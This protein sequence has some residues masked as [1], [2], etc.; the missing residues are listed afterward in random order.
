M[1]VHMRLHT[2]SKP[3]KCPHCDQW[4]R[5]SG[6]RK[7]H[8]A[9]HFKP[10]NPK[11]RR[12]GRAGVGGATEEP[13]QQ[14]VL[15]SNSGDLQITNLSALTPEQIAALTGA[16]GA[17]Q[18]VN[19]DQNQ[20]QQL[21]QPQ[22]QPLSLSITTDSFGNITD[23]ALATQLLQNIEGLQL[24]IPQQQQQQVQIGGLDNLAQ[25]TIQID[26]ALLQQLQQ[27]NIN[28]TIDPGSFQQLQTA[29]PNLI[30]PSAAPLNPNV[31]ISGTED[32]N[33]PTEDEN[34]ELQQQTEQNAEETDEEDEEDED[35][36]E[37][38]VDPELF[39]NSML[40]TIKTE[41][42]MVVLHQQQQQGTSTADAQQNPLRKH[43]CEVQW[44][45]DVMQ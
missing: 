31:L 38:N 4:F 34:T 10:T 6:H 16:G 26:P 8:I 24:Q 13:M 19:I 12:S 25:Q 39:D 11:K 30:Q 27:G 9:Q 15:N 37:D 5:T 3:F 35:E 21:Q 7:S 44:L 22:Q 28:L 2:G 1:K 40:Q 36:E 33:K 32:I 23:P 42:G 45:P 14:I 43:V 18:V 20:L 29:N 41:D 17:Q